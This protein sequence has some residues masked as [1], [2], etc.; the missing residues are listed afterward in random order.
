MALLRGTG[1]RLQTVIFYGI[2][3]LRRCQNRDS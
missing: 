2:Y 1:L 3:G